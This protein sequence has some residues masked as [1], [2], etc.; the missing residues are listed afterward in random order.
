MSAVAAAASSRWILGP[1]RD[2]ALFIATPLLILPALALARLQFTAESIGLAVAALGAQGHH[3]PGLLRAYGDRELF[4]RYRLRFIAAPI[5]L[6]G[7][8]WACRHLG[9]EGLE[10]VIFFWAL[11]HGLAQVYGFIRIYDAKAGG[12]GRRRAQLDLAMCVVWFAGA[13]LFAPDKLAQIL[14][15]FYSSGGPFLPPGT[16]AAGRIAWGVV[17]LAVTAAFAAATL[18]D[19]RRG[20]SPCPPKLALMASSFGFWWVCTTLI[21]PTI[22]GVA[23]F[24]IFHDVQ[25]LAIVWV[26]NRARVAKGRPVGVFTR[27]LF[28]PSVGLVVLY[29]GLVFAYGGLALFDRRVQ[30][31]EDLRLTIY[32]LIAASGLLHYYFDGFIWKIREAETSTAL[33]V[34]A[35]AGGPAATLRGP[36]LWH[37]LRWGGFA[38][39]AVALFLGQTWNRAADLVQKEAVVA[40][41]PDSA[42]ARQNLGVALNGLDRRE[43]AVQEFATAVR[44]RPDFAK[45][46]LNWGT[47]LTKLGRGEEALGHFR[48]ALRL[49]PGLA[50][51]HL[52][53]GNTLLALGR[54]REA[55]SRFEEA[56][57]GLGTSEAHNNLA[58]MLSNFSRHAEAER[59]Y[60]AA[61]RL[62][63]TSVNPWVNWGNA[64][65]RQRRFREA[66][67]HYRAAHAIDPQA[68]DPQLYWGL[69]LAGSGDTTAARARLAAVVAL[70]PDHPVAAAMLARLD[71][72]AEVGRPGGLPP[73]VP[74]GPP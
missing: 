38:L 18:A 57:R 60:A 63:P 10:L 1:W 39:P 54:P 73:S 41:V 32:G 58:N 22:L 47:A 35:R 69:A 15:A 6:V 33:G 19:W 29:L 62:D 34:A 64:L 49:D 25:Y 55:L 14:T 4:A 12:T 37:G 23:A 13:V 40:A 68:V 8:C 53:W 43:E 74:G 66:I 50:A 51:V 70:A 65:A 67:D 45:A 36:W 30:G 7:L 61:V 24:E 20:V 52:S 56:V 28:R 2:A 16:I 44:L 46:R 42:N 5:L 11:W 27:F 17:A 48:E 21:S 26:F 72:V 9:L 71:S 3:L 31:N 59:H